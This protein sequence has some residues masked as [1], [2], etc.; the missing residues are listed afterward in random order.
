MEESLPDFL[1]LPFSILY[2]PM[3]IEQLDSVTAFITDRDRVC[4]EEL[5]L[6]WI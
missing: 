4:E 1:F 6:I 3:T 2:H 5:L